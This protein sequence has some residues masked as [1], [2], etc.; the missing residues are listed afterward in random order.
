MKPFDYLNSINS[1]KTDI[2]DSDEAEK[3]YNPYLINRSLT[4]FVTQFSFLMR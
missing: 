1:N 3:I 2:M 4:T